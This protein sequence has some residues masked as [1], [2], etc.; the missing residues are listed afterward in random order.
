[1]SKSE[2]SARDEVVDP[3]W[4]A[5]EL[6]VSG[7]RVT[8]VPAQERHEPWETPVAFV[9]PSLQCVVQNGCDNQRHCWARSKHG[10]YNIVELHKD[11]F[12]CQIQTERIPRRRLLN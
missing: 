2:E 12:R 11:I 8:F 4:E 7:V 9:A 5:V 1:M 3:D 10:V 6:L